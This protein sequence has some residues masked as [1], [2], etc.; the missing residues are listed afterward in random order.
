[1]IGNK[2]FSITCDGKTFGTNRMY[3][4]GRV[5]RVK[6]L[7]SSEM[8]PTRVRI[9]LYLNAKYISHVCFCCLALFLDCMSA[10]FLM[11]VDIHEKD[12][13][14]AEKEKESRDTCKRQ[15]RHRKRQQTYS[16]NTRNRKTDKCLHIWYVHVLRQMSDCQHTHTNTHRRLDHTLEVNTNESNHCK[17]VRNWGRHLHLHR[18]HSR[19]RIGGGPG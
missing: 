11:N 15:Q 18:L 1:M 3:T 6:D 9:P 16:F 13:R 4:S 10:V 14:L 2:C 17:S 12:S 5:V 7:W 8:A 19:I